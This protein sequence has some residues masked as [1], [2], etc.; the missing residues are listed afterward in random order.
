M[1]VED[2]LWGCELCQPRSWYFL[3]TATL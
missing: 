3:P 1:M 2:N